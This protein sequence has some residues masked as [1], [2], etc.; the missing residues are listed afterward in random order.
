VALTAVMHIIGLKLN[1]SSI[2]EGLISESGKR[3]FPLKTLPLHHLNSLLKKLKYTQRSSFYWHICVC[4]RACVCMCVHIF[5]VLRQ[6]CDITK[7]ALHSTL[8]LNNAR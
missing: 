8:L 5:C 3:I 6:T 4:V 2:L 1:I 7:I